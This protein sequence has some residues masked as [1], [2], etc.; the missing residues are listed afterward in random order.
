MVFRL[1]D[2]AIGLAVFCNDETF[3]GEMVKTVFMMVI[4]EM[5]GL[6]GMVDWED[7][8]LLKKLREAGEGEKVSESYRSNTTDISGTYHHPAYGNLIVKRIEDHPMGPTFSRLLA[9]YPGHSIPLRPNEQIYLG[10]LPQKWI[11]KLLLSISDANL[12]T[13]AWIR[14]DEIVRPG[15]ADMRYAGVVNGIGK[16]M[17]LDKGIG[18][19]WDFCGASG[20]G[21]DVS[22]WAEED[23]E[24]AAA[25]W[26]EKIST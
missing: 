17:I 10:D 1:P 7:V 25:L 20:E 23:A 22:E 14:A 6:G 18:M 11:G 9:E 13:R 19:P 21:A 2:D 24:H 3:G 8:Y 5:L 12:F 26:F 16:C 15:E 4:D